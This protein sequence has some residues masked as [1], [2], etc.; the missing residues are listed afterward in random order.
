[1]TLFANREDAGR[2]LAQR[3]L[4]LRLSKPVVLAL[5]RGGVPIEAILARYQLS[6]TLRTASGGWS[7]KWPQ[8]IVMKRR[9]TLCGS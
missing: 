8:S 7:L 4:E 6:G 9:R 2:R 1:M 5:P 3:L